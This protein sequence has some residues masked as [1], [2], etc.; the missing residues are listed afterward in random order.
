MSRARYEKVSSLFAQVC[1][2]AKQRGLDVGLRH[3]ASSA[4]VRVDSP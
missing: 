3:A 1:D 2:A 4:G